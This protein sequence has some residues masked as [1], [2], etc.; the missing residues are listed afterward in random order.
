MSSLQSLKYKNL[1][2]FS[3]A[4]ERLYTPYQLVYAILLKSW[5]TDPGS[6]SHLNM[7]RQAAPS[8]RDDTARQR[9]FLQRQKNGYLPG[10]H[11]KEDAVR[12]KDKKIPETKSKQR[13]AL[14]LWLE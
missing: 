10:A 9:R 5:L 3:L 6:D 8:R 13:E 14:N 1:A 12:N 7:D 11:R 4:F 2:R